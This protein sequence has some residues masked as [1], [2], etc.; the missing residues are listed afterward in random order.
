MKLDLIDRWWHGA[1][2]EDP[3]ELFLKIVADPNRLGETL[4]FELLHLLPLFLVLFLRVAEE[5]GMNKISA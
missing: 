2:F 4:T 3:I 5:W 1:G